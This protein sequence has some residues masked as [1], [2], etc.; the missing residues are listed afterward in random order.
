MLIGYNTNVTYRGKIYHVQTED[1]GLG[2]P[3]IVTHLYHH[4][5]ILYSKKTN[6]A[7]IITHHDFKEQLRNMMKQQ[8]KE[9]IK[10]LLKGRL[11][12]EQ[13]VISEEETPV[14]NED[15][16]GSKSSR[17]KERSLDEI[18]IEHIAKRAKN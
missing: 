2:N 18:L 7:N 12:G 4:G 13:A 14:T 16:L 3:V 15:N 5:A 8:H 11:T 6:Y 9:M 1:S 17:V 10:E